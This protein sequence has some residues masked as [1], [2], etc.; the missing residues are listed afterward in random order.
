MAKMLSDTISLRGL[1]LFEQLGLSNSMQEAS[2]KVGL[3]MSAASQQ[4]RNLEEAV[5]YQLVDHGCRPLKL[6]PEG[7]AYFVHIRSALE[8]LR[9]GNAE[10]SLADI[11][12]IKSLRVGII[13]DFDS[14][15]SPR[16][17][18]ALA[19]A[20]KL[21]QLSLVTSPSIQMINDVSSQSIDIAIASRALD[22]P[23]NVTEL[24]IVRDPF[25]VAVP[26]GHLS[27]APSSID[28]LADLSY[29]RYESSQLIARQITTHLSRLKLAPESW[30]EVD[31]NQALFG[32]VASGTGWATTTPIGFMRARRYH[33]AVDIYPLPYS[34][35][36]RTISIFYRD[37]WMQRVAE[38]ISEQ[39]RRIV[40]NEIID[41]C[42]STIPWINERLSI[43]ND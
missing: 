5:G 3:S 14:E 27:K 16:L 24:P 12:S 43:L 7:R 28:D 25:I 21:G 23:A 22:L 11:G 20:L 15:V 32:L 4:L 1:E 6:N 34:D 17:A 9:L 29:L 31:S 37:S 41:P 39:L 36:S 13:D 42:Q 38:T 40:Q 10:L 33:D 30:I 2:A 26:R 35:F 19:K 18:V 8:Q